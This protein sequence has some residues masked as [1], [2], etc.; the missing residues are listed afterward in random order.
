MV[1]RAVEELGIDLTGSWVVGDKQ[2]DIELA[3]N[4]GIPGILV[5]TGYG[6]NYEHSI[7]AKDLSE[8]VS[9]VEKGRLLS[10]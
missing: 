3:E 5:L 8:V 9:I 4:L 10:Y 2:S 7:K 1:D 6:K